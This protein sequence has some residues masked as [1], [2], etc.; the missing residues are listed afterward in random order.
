MI[1]VGKRTFKDI[2]FDSIII[3]IVGVAALSCLLPILNTLAISLSS[4]GKAAAGAVYFW[5][6]DL[7]LTSYERLLS[8]TNFLNAFGTS[9]KRVLL[10]TSLN[11]LLSILMAY[12]LSKRTAVFRA[13]NVYLWL[14]VFTMLFSGGLIPWF[15]TIKTLGLLDTIWALVLPGAMNV[16]NTI[17]LMNFFRGVSSE[18]DDAALVDGAGPLRIAF[19]IFVP[20]S[21]PVIA[22]LTL[23]SAVGHWNSFFD[24]LILMNKPINYPLQTY[25]QRLVVNTDI[26]KI[27]DIEEFKRLMEISGM[28]FNAAKIF[29]S[30]IPILLIYPFLQKYFVKGIVLGSVK[31]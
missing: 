16:W 20:V 3:T 8:D 22:T 17:M 4:K 12:P 9:T 24:G 6:V 25:I 1:G 30:M 10:G 5:P 18:L 15:L 7:T 28:T 27:K 26:N 31:E 29:V 14:L 23:F 2:F 19:Q 21:K 13:R 11:M